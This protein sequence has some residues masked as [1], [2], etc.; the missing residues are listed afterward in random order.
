MGQVL[1][2]ERIYA[3]ITLRLIVNTSEVACNINLRALF[4]HLLILMP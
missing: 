1:K 2:V 3:T 4:I